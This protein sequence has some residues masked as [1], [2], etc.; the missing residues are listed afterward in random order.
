MIN[1]PAWLELD[2]YVGDLGALTPFNFDSLPFRPRNSF[3]VKDVPVGAVRG[4]HAHRTCD[5]ALFVLAGAVMA[6]TTDGIESDQFHLSSPNRGLFVP[7]MFWGQ[8][9]YLTSDA[10]LLVFSSEPY[11]RDDYIESFTQFIDLKKCG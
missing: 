2:D 1:R 5:Q 10:V 4:K 3:V 9:K 8:Q 6:S 7:K 11:S